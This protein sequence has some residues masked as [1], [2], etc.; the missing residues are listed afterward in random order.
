MLDFIFSSGLLQ[1][2][3]YGVQKLKFARGKEET[4]PK[5]ILTSRYS[6]V[7]G[8]FKEACKNVN[9]DALSD[10]SLWNILNTLKPSRQRSLAGLD[11]I[12]AAGMNRFNILQTVSKGSYCNDHELRNVLER[13]RKY[14]N[15]RYAL[16]FSEEFEIASHNCLYALSDPNEDRYRVIPKCLVKKVPLADSDTIYDVDNAI[17][18]IID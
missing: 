8:L 5:A 18:D 14:L 1:D 6:H 10:S 9:Y 15:T 16:N 2:T 3:A 13:G 12:V 11:D 7:I 17:K 4:V